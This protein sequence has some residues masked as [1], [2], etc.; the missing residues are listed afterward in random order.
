MKQ[1]RAVTVTNQLV[2]TRQILFAAVGEP[3]DVQHEGKY[4]YWYYKCSDG[5]VQLAF[6]LDPDIMGDQ[7][8]AE[9]SDE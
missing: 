2:T 5:A 3:D 8:I 9:L 1:R 6:K 4:T 7:I